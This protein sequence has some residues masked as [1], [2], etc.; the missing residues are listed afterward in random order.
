MADYVAAYDDISAQLVQAQ[1]DL[2]DADTLLVK[3]KTARDTAYLRSTTLENV[4]LGLGMLSEVLPV[5][6]KREA[7]AALA[8][9]APAVS[10]IVIA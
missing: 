5:L 10:A 4:K 2:K 8:V 7:D 1:Q 3:A 6:A 9:A